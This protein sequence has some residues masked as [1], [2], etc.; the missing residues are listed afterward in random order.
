MLGMEE[1]M[2]RQIFRLDAR[3]LDL[4]G[5][6]MTLQEFVGFMEVMMNS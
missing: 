5:R 1:S 2:I 6:T 3:D 4:D